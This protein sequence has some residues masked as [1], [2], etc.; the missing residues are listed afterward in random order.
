MNTSTS[1]DLEPQNTPEFILA[2]FYCERGW[3]VCL[4]MT[5]GWT[6][7]CTLTAVDIED[8]E[9]VVSFTLFDIDHPDGETHTLPLDHVQ[10]LHVY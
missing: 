2:T 10:H 4:T 1:G 9:A 6:C 5:N 7:D 8:G 3:V